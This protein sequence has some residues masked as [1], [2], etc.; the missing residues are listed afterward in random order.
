MKI[1]SVGA[2]F[3]ADGQTDRQDE[4]YNR[5]SQFCSRTILFRKSGIT[6]YKIPLIAAQTY[7]KN[8][9]RTNISGLTAA[10]EHQR[11]R[12]YTRFLLPCWMDVA[13]F[14][15]PAGITQGPDVECSS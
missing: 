8:Q 12:T 7:Y 15:R 14:W 4:A 11:S 2:E 6:G 13:G 1:R 5:F 9:T 3:H 10:A